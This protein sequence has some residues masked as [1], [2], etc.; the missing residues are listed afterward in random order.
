MAEN[1][2]R[3]ALGRLC[4]YVSNQ[5]TRLGF[6]GTLVP[7]YAGPSKG[8]EIMATVNASDTWTGPL[9]DDMAEDTK[10][11]VDAVDAVFANL[12]WDVRNERNALP[13]EVP[14]DDPDA[15][16]PNGGV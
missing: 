5:N 12:F 11:D 1:L 10:A 13:A 16:W 8:A 14:E 9:A 4:E 7:R 15:N 6:D 2:R 3:Q